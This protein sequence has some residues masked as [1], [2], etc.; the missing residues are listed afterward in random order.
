MAS[1]PWIHAW[2]AIESPGLAVRNSWVLPLYISFTKKICGVG[3]T[4]NA[5]T[6]EISRHRAEAFSRNFS[7]IWEAS[8]LSSELLSWIL[9][10]ARYSSSYEKI[11]NEELIFIEKWTKLAAWRMRKCI[12]ALLKTIPVSQ[13]SPRL[14]TS[15]LWVIDGMF[16][17]NPALVSFSWVAVDSRKKD[18]W[19]KETR[20]IYMLTLALNQ[21]GLGYIIQPKNAAHAEDWISNMKISI[22]EWVGMQGPWG[23]LGLGCPLAS[24]ETTCSFIIILPS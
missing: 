12:L 16:D 23:I 4:L 2:T 1:F 13:T 7:I 9:F 11:V 5:L 19:V 17:F 18:Y 24:G 15:A 10:S 6:P 14:S 20:D 21:K 3:R 8:R 22:H